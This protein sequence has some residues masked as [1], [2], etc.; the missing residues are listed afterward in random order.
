MLAAADA[1]EGRLDAAAARIDEAIAVMERTGELWHEAHLR[2]AKSRFLAAND[3]AA[4]AHVRR[5]LDVAR[6]QGA[7]LF[8]LRAALALA[9]RWRQRGHAG[10]AR[11]ARRSS[12][13]VR[14]RPPLLPDIRP[15]VGCSPRS[16]RR[17]D[18]GDSYRRITATPSP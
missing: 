13:L 8:E 18:A 6:S 5:A 9:R 2:I 12:R 15:H 4:E 3:P 7:R 16:A 17:R 1:I 14:G 11:A 10:E